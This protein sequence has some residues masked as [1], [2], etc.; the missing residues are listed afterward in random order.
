MNKDAACIFDPEAIGDVDEIAVIHLN[1]FDH[2]AALIIDHTFGI[3][4]RDD[5]HMLG[6]DLVVGNADVAVRTRGD[7]GSLG[8]AL[9][10]RR[11]VHM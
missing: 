6:V 11:T 5:T 10:S 9:H 8:N 7:P 3:F 2:Q 4:M 1:G